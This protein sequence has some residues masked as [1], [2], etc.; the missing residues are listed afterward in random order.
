MDGSDRVR[1]LRTTDGN[2]I[3]IEEV[4]LLRR[5]PRWLA[6][7]GSGQAQAEHTHWVLLAKGA[8]TDTSSCSKLPHQV[9]PVLQGWCHLQLGHLT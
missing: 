9:C 1:L 7:A 2:N 5:W 4:S 8:L 3:I 6:E